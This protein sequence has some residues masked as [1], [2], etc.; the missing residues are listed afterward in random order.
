[1]LWKVVHPHGRIS[2]VNWIAAAEGSSAAILLEADVGLLTDKV[3][4]SQPVN[5]NKCKLISLYI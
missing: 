1:M 5:I 2:V 4:I 3:C